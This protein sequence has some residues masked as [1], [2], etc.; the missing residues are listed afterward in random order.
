MATPTI[1]V[2]QILHK[3]KLE[4]QE[5][6]PEFLPL[7]N[8]SFIIYIVLSEFGNAASRSLTLKDTKQCFVCQKRRQVKQTTQYN[9]PIFKSE[10]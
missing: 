9:I 4:C 10:K 2:T 5:K 1:Y 8:V 6:S 3:Q 7:F